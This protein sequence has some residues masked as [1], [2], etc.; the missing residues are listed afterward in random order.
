MDMDIFFSDLQTYLTKFVI[1]LNQTTI[2]ELIKTNLS[3]LTCALG[4][5]QL[6]YLFFI[7]EKKTSTFIFQT[8]I[9]TIFLNILITRT[10]LSILSYVFK[11]LNQSHQMIFENKI[12][13][14]INPWYP[15]HILSFVALFLSLFLVFFHYFSV[16]KKLDSKYQLPKFTLFTLLFLIFTSRPISHLINQLLQF[17]FTN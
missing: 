3:F 8:L 11:K 16:N 4:F 17:F 7:N 6:L 10:S 12:L 13:F 1:Y 14:A 15:K 9:L 5:G 2:K